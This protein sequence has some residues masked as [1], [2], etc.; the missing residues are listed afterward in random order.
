MRNRF[1][2]AV[3]AVALLFAVCG[4]ALAK[5]TLIIYTSMKESLIG[6]IVE[7]FNKKFPDIAVDYQSAGA[8]KLMAKIAAER[9]SGKI[10]ADMIWTSEVPDF[11]SMK[12]QG[13][14]EQ[15][16][17]PLIGEILNPFDDYDG[18]FTAARLGTLGIAINTDQIKTPPTQWSDLFKPEYKGAFGIADP[19]LSG[20]SYMSVA[21]LDKQFGWE[22][23]DKLYGNKARIGKGS[24]QVVDDTASGELA[25]SLAVDY[26]TN[27]KIAKGAHIA[28]YYP[29]E[30]L[31]APSP[32]AIFKNSPNIE[33]AK[34]FLDYLLSHDAQVLVAG[35]GTLS[36]RTDVKNADGFMLPEAQDALKRAIKIDYLEMMA[37]KEALIKKFTDTLQGKK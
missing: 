7:G 4:E 10:L 1:V 5:E 14:L 29:P 11:Y 33:A 25:A 26:I 3:L 24:G 36:V 32:I 20:T 19:A 30:L 17:T 13:I 18:H 8:G 35:E 6:G 28:L 34:K 23:F 2:V 16:K 27:D 15:Y 22:F 21:L 9:E 31:M 37:G 12:Q